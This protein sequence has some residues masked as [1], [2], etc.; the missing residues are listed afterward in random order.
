MIVKNTICNISDWSIFLSLS[1]FSPKFFNYKVKKTPDQIHI[2]WFP[3][4]Y[5]PFYLYLILLVLN[6]E[7]NIYLTLN[8][9]S[10]KTLMQAG[11]IYSPIHNLL[12]LISFAG[13]TQMS[14]GKNPPFSFLL[15]RNICAFCYEISINLIYSFD[16][17]VVPS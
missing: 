12:K 4:A 2:H 8:A 15:R 9:T 1:F 7:L 5:I 11:E 3:T 16:V 6:K 14:K 17:W 13:S 10:L